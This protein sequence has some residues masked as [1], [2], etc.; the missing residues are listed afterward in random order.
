MIAPANLQD[1]IYAYPAV[2][3]DGEIYGFFNVFRVVMGSGLLD[4][5][6]QTTTH[7]DHIQIRLSHCGLIAEVFL[8]NLKVERSLYPTPPLQSPLTQSPTSP[9]R[10][11]NIGNSPTP[12]H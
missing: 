12:D 11:A 1:I 4:A 3:V 8:Y 9:G 10:S 6:W 2:A 7:L 5:S